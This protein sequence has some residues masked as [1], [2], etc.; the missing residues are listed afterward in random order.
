MTGVKVEFTF[1]EEFLIELRAEIKKAV[2]DAL[3]ENVDAIRSQEKKLTR[4]EAASKLRI[5]LPT[6]DKF[7]NEKRIAAQCIGKR[8]LIPES[9]IENYLKKSA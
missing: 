5:S 8:I 4:K 1:P 3:H 9:E 6:L 7:L 2:V